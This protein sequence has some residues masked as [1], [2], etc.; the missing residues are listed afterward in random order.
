M[1]FSTSLATDLARL[2][3]SFEMSLAVLETVS[4]TLSVLPSRRSREI[5]LVVPATLSIAMSVFT[6]SVIFSICLPKGA[7]IASGVKKVTCKA[8]NITST[9]PKVRI[10][11]FF[12]FCSAKDLNT[13]T[14]LLKELA[15]PALFE[16][17]ILF[18][19]HLTNAIK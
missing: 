10:T 2:P 4:I 1:P 14:K 3:N 16:L 18:N 11:F 19:L 5:C 9:T 15:K 8:V 17:D 6:P 13:A 12:K 7:A